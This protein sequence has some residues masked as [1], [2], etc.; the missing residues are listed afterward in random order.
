MNRRPIFTALAALALP[1]VFV[2]AKIAARW[3]PVK[4]ADV[5]VDER[6]FAVGIEMGDNFLAVNRQNA[7]VIS[8]TFYD[9]NSGARLHRSGRPIDDGPWTWNVRPKNG[10]PAWEQQLV[11]EDGKGAVFAFDL[12]AEKTYAERDFR[13][14]RFATGSGLEVVAHQEF[15]QWPTH[16]AVPARRVA[17]QYG[18]NVARFVPDKAEI[19]AASS[20]E[21]LTLS[22]RTGQIIRRVSLAQVHPTNYIMKSVKANYLIQNAVDTQSSVEPIWNVFSTRTGRV[23]WQFSQE[24]TFYG[25]ALTSD[26]AEAALPFPSRKLWEIRAL[27]TGKFLRTLPLVPGAQAAAFS[28]DGAT[29]Y[30]VAGGVLYRQRAR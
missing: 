8:T 23:L 11:L 27:E 29:L 26:E 22:T 24:N 14:L 7:S 2:A 5:P 17:L 12:P 9:A 18:C 30:S 10:A 4:I 6:A 28:P 15:L 1:A 19:M 3:R 13:V 20:T 21:F 16:S 25:P